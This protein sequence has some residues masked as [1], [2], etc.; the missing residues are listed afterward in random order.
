MYLSPS[1]EPM[2]T[3]HIRGISTL[4]KVADYIAYVYLI[5]KETSF[6]DLV[7]RETLHTETIS[8]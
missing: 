4:G 2:C 5:P 6:I 1:I 3:T 7:V 8:P